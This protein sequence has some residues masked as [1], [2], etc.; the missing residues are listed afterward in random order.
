MIMVV[1]DNYT[2]KLDGVWL[3]GKDQITAALRH[4]RSVDPEAD[5]SLIMARRSSVE[6]GN[7]MM[8]LIYE[9]GLHGGFVETQ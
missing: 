2:V 9:E 4:V 3:H 5:I 8:D 6:D 7:Q 1:E